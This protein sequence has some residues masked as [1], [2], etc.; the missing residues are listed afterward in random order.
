MME[1]EKFDLVTIE[2]ATH[3]KLLT[4]FTVDG[5]DPVLK[6]ITEEARAHVPDL[7]TDKGRKA[8][9]SNAYRVSQTKTVLGKIARNLTADMKAQCKVIDASIKKM[10]DSCD[11]LRDESRQLLT[12]WETAE[13][14][15]EAAEKLAAE[16]EY[17]HELALLEYAVVRREAE[18][19]KKEEAARVEEEARLERERVA[20]AEKDRIDREEVVRQEAVAAEKLA[21]EE[22]KKRVAKEAS[23]KIDE[24]KRKTREAEINAEIEKREAKE[25]EERAKLQAAEEKQK[26]I[27]DERKR[28]EDEAAAVLAETAKRE[29]NTAHKKKIN[30]AALSALC[31][32]VTEA[33]AK[34]IIDAIAKSEVPHVRIEY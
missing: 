5:V 29:A 1:N 9:A 2:N 21:A 8:I 11:A 3:E 33:E 7:T 15:R 10:E 13:K 34:K 16:V 12:D 30:N 25:R 22:E 24:A 14:E 32:I 4:I 19:A 17:D 26:A 27:D 20:Q 31:G 28:V 6:W 18:V 23:D